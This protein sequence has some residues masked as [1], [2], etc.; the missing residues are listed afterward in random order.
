MVQFSSHL[1]AS[2]RRVSQVLCNDSSDNLVDVCRI[3]HRH[4][5]LNVGRAACNFQRLLSAALKT[6]LL[7]TETFDWA[8][9]LDKLEGNSLPF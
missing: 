7:P 2:A 6:A 1:L 5:N 3:G 9:S 8:P 4:T